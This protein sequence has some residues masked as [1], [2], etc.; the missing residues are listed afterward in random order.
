MSGRGLLATDV[1][2]SHYARTDSGFRFATVHSNEEVF[3]D[4]HKEVNKIILHQK[5]ISVV[6]AY[7][8]SAD[9]DAVNKANFV[10]IPNSAH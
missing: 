9:S 4:V 10:T 5:E 2:T 8:K 6:S 1:T 3:V 7:F